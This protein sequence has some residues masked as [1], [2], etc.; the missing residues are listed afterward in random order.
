MKLVGKYNSMH[1]MVMSLEPNPLCR[2]YCQLLKKLYSGAVPLAAGLIMQYH[3]V[4]FENAQ[5]P[6]RFSRT[7]GAGDNWESLRL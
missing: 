2:D 1:G 4:L 6:E 5:L 3:K 7:F